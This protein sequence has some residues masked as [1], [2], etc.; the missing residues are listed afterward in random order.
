MRRLLI[1]LLI[2]SLGSD[3]LGQQ[4]QSRP[5][6]TEATAS[7]KLPARHG[8]YFGLTLLELHRDGAVDLRIE[9]FAGSEA[10]S[11]GFKTGDL[12]RAI[13]GSAIKHGDDFIQKLYGTM[14]R[15]GRSQKQDHTI[16]V[17]RGDERIDIPGGMDQLDA[18]PAVGDKAP[19]FTLLDGNGE[20]Q[21]DLA[22]LIGD[23]P[24]FLVFGS[25]T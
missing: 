15:D 9:V 13:D 25:Y 19:L 4:A 18:H 7:E 22:S 14:S 24:V 6:P 23:K 16:T 10:E 17:Q 1:P 5:S 2:L 20:E 3:L 12:I 8:G 21:I 11:M